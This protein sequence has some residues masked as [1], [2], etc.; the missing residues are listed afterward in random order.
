MMSAT[1]IRV[2]WEKKRLNVLESMAYTYFNQFLKMRQCT[3]TRCACV[4][5]KDDLKIKEKFL[6]RNSEEA[7]LEK[8]YNNFHLFI[9]RD[10][11][12]L[13]CM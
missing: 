5:H 4:I 13:F 11:S 8:R 6:I 10:I 2:N 9:A 1:I 7:R 3:E 12:L